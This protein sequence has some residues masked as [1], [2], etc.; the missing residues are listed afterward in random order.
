MQHSATL[1]LL[2]GLLASPMLLLE[3]ITGPLAFGPTV[4]LVLSPAHPLSVRGRADVW[5]WGLRTLLLVTDP[6]GRA[7]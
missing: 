2:R 1:S 4:P 5:A 3:S 6:E 7:I